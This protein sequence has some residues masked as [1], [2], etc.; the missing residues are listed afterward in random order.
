[1]RT[2]LATAV[3]L[4][5]VYAVF[6]RTW[7]KRHL[8]GVQLEVAISICRLATAIIYGL[9]F[10]DLIQS[11]QKAIGMLRHPLLFGGLATALTVPL[12]FQGWSLNGG[13]AVALVFALTSIVV[14][15]REEILYR[16]VLINL[17]QP[18]I[19]ISGAV[20]CSTALFVVYHYGAMPVTWLA[21]IEVASLSLLMALVYVRSGS[22]LTVI[23]FHAIYDGAWFF[24][25]ALAVPLPDQWRP[26]FLLSALSLVAFW[27]RLTAP[28]IGSPGHP[29][30]GKP[31]S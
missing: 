20:L 11:R 22:L 30:V 27:W 9:L 7:L 13:F 6:T 17:L 3:A 18:R 21:V 26:L 16:A 29:P 23:A 2:K 15:V 28:A 25:P 8:E 12:L 10:R 24:G 14:G 31:R 4:E 1:M 19:G 5:I